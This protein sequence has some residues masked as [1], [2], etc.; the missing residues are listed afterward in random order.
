MTLLPDPQHPL[1]EA[2]AEAAFAAILDGAVADEAIARFLVGLSDRGENASEIAGAARA[3]RARMIPIKAPANAIDV[4]GTGGDGHHTLNVSTAVSLVV[5]A[6]GV[7][8]AK[9]GNRAAS[10][11]AGAADTLEALGLNL[12]RAAETAEETLADLG[13]CFLFAARHHP[14]M[15]RIMPIRKALGRRTIF[16]LMGPLA[17]P[18]NVR[19]QLVGIARPAYVPIYAEAILRLGTD[20]SF[21][22]SGDEGLDELSLAGGNEL[23]EVRDGEISMRRVTPADAGLPESAVTAIRGGD[24]AHNARALRALLE[25]EHGPYRNAVLFNAAAALII[26]GE[27]QDWHEGVEEAAEAIDKGLANA[28]LNCWIAALE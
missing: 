19:R 28:L 26:A 5:A 1:E 9:H 21:V 2:E 22:I 8:V 3:M 18:A 6:C 27:A 11:K 7:P 4:C 14:S 23:A 20:H 13:I 15:G 17:N 25:G 24:A 12:D 16:N 10:S